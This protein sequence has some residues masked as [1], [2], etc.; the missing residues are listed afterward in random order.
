MREKYGTLSLQEITEQEFEGKTLTRKS[1]MVLS[2]FGS[3]RSNL[4]RMEL[5]K[6]EGKHQSQ[7]SNKHLKSKLRR[8]SETF[9][10]SNIL[11]L[12]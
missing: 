2:K 9:V 1:S 4:L 3:V 7:R 11:T 12:N 5:L 8:N 6:S 10:L